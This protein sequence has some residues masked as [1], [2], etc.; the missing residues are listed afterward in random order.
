VQTN[1]VGQLGRNDGNS[2]LFGDDANE[3]GDNLPFLDFGSVTVTEL[4]SAGSHSCVITTDAKDNV[5]CWGRNNI[6]DIGTGD[7]NN[8][9]D[10]AGEMGNNLPFLN[11]GGKAVAV[12]LADYYGCAL[13]SNA[14]VT[15]WGSYIVSGWES[16][17]NGKTPVTISVG[18]NAGIPVAVFAG[19]NNA[20]VLLNTSRIKCWGACLLTT[21]CFSQAY[22]PLV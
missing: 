10:T 11:I 8:R 14:T 2:G 12:A 3:M 7:T 19:G 9:G 16:T 17:Q 6:Y 18:T 22:K 20:C 1:S 13:L 4:V 15:C 21:T 5:K